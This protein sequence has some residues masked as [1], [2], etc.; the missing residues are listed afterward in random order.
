MEKALLQSE[1][2][3]FQNSARNCLI[4]GATGCLAGAV[5]ELFVIAIAF[6][7]HN[8]KLTHNIFIAEQF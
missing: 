8:G 2:V 7:K 1:V 5:S 3:A 4:D 6:V